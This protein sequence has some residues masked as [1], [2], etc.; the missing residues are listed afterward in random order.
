MAHEERWPL[1]QI[2]EL[3]E[4]VAELRASVRHLE[5]EVADLRQEFR[6]DVRRLDARLFQILLGQLATLGAALAALATT[7]AG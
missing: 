4:G 7:L 1:G 5:A 2:V 6:A 3:R